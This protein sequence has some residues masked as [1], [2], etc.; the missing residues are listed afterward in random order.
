MKYLIFELFSGVGLCNQLFSFETAVYLANILDRKLLLVIKNPLCHCGR[1][2]WDYGYLLNFFTTDYY[3]FLPHGLDVYYKDVPS[4]VAEKMNDSN[5]IMNEHKFSYVVFI[6]ADLNIESNKQHISDFCHNR[7]TVIFDVNEHDDKEYV[8]ISKSNASRFFYNFYT[9]KEN[10]QLMYDI[11]CA[12]KFKQIYYDI[13]NMI[14]YQLPRSKN[15]LLVF[16]H[17]RF[18]DFHKDMTFLERSNAE[19]IRNISEFIDTHKTNMISHSLYFLIDNKKNEKFLNAMKKYRYNFIDEKVTNVY[20]NF[21]NENKMV[22]YDVNDVKRYEVTDAI[23][24]MII[25]SKADEFIGYYSSTFSNYIQFLRFCNHKSHSYYSNYQTKNTRYCKLMQIKDSDIEW[26]RIGFRGGHP[27]AWGYFF[28]P[29]PDNSNINFTISGK[30]D[31]FGSQLQACFSMIAYCHYKG[32][33]YIHNEFYRMHHN[34]EN[35]D[36]FPKVMN[37]FVNLE[38]KFR[39]FKSLTNNEISKVHMAKEGYFVHGSYSPEVF[40]NEPVLNLLRECYYSNPKPDIS[41]IYSNSIYNV[42][43]HIRRGDVSDKAH[44]SRYTKNE[45][46]I[47][48]LKSIELPANAQLHIFS[49]GSPEDFND[50]KIA[51]PNIRLHISINIQ[52]T[53]HCF[54]EADLLIMSKSSFCYSA[55]L[56]N[57][58]K[59]NGTFIKNWWHKPLKSWI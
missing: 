36:Q 44:W 13:A 7:N 43:V 23:I 51:F 56:L 55:G 31:G 3:K 52:T 24:E 41:K 17:L 37:D 10:Y 30:T 32:Y 21:I 4:E 28:K 35:V 2:T 16:A 48:L 12:I 38:H 42:A 1:A 9:K 22:F 33:N 49:E 18:G 47:H 50:F 15:N 58:N 29:I 54:V 39:S 59:V 19:M 14:Y 6:D 26:Q 40:Y 27:L 5:V 53:F 25:A 45:E 11:S 57:K 8:Y 46:Y 20:S 34:D